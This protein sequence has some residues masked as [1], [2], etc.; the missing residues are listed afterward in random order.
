MMIC[1][2]FK[3]YEI[4]ENA[5]SSQKG[6]ALI[7]VLLL[8]ATLSVIAI[9]LTDQTLIAA[10]RSRHEAARTQMLWRMHGAEALATQLLSQALTQRPVMSIDDVWANQPFDLAALAS[11]ENERGQIQFTDSTRCFNLNSLAIDTSRDAAPGEPIVD[12]TL[13]EFITLL[14][15]VGVS[16]SDARQ[17]GVVIRD[18]VDPDQDPSIGGAEDST[19]LRLPVP[20]RTGNTLIT[21]ESEL[22]SM[23]GVDPLLLTVISPLV[24]ALPT[25]Q[26]SIVNVNMLREQDAPVLVGI[27]EGELS[28]SS[29]EALIID[30]PVQGYESVADII[31]SSALA[32]TPAAAY[33]NRLSVTSNY[34]KARLNLEFGNT[35][36]ESTMLYEV[37]TEG[38]LD[39]VSRRFGSDQ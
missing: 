31:A 4:R 33:Q 10:A 12:Q 37:S 22:R 32:G 1:T 6:A 9:G 28:L 7:I 2:R 38:R 26:P 25:D 27:F 29:A 36:L 16:Q 18:W 30:R 24:C 20:Y 19:Y 34:L 21:D 5:L 13:E 14:G 11:T 17:L 3:T 8:V 35:I 39:L 23:L 15:S